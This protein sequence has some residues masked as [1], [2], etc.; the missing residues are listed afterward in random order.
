MP[1][2]Q[3]TKSIDHISSHYPPSTIGRAKLKSRPKKPA[4]APRPA[5]APIV[6]CVT[7]SDPG[8]TVQMI[9]PMG[10]SVML[11]PNIAHS[12]G[13]FQ[14]WN[15]ECEE[16]VRPK[17]KYVRTSTVTRCSKCGEDMK[18]PDHSQYMGYWYC[19][20]KDNIP[21]QEWRDN[22]QKAGVARK[23]KSQR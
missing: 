23:K 8:I 22:L 15:Q 6:P 13:Q 12:T 18:P 5:V 16:V 14:T 19:A 4:L 3:S 11:I 10:N 9:F 20:R 2:A 1:T 21:F 7:S 17:R